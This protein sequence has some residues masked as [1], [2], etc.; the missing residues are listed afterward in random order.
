MIGGWVKTEE[1]GAKILGA[2]GEEGSEFGQTAGLS[3]LDWL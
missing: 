2:S 1:D 3:R